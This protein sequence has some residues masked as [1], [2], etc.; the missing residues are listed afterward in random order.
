MTTAVTPEVLTDPELHAHGDPHEVWRWMRRHAPVHRHPATALPAFWSMTRYDDVRAVYRDPE[1]FSSRHGV[2]LRPVDRGVD[3]GG[4]LTLALSDPPRHKQ[5]RAVVADWFST[6]AVRDL[7]ET[8]LQAVRD[9]LD[10]LPA[11]GTCEFAHDVAG[12]LSMY[13][14]GGIIGVPRHDHER[15]FRWTNEAFAAGVSLAAHQ[16]LMRYFID[17]MGRRTAE[18]TDDLVSALLGGTIDGELLTEEEILL[19]CENIIGATEN[20]GLA[21]AGGMLALVQHPDEWRRLA[22]DPEALPG[23]VE[24]ILRWTSSA[25]HSMRT[26]TRDCEVAGQTIAAGDRVVLWVPSA[27][28]DEDVFPEP[29]RFDVGRSP[30]RHLALGSGEHFCLGATLARSQMRLLLKELLE[31]TARIELCG[32]VHRIS[33]IAVSGPESLPLRLVPR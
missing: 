8:T 15:L 23:A 27:N 12:R 9:V 31:R 18:P 22:E 10:R 5:L 6:R 32:P 7:E 26:A 13:L 20:G 14:I 24:E 25:T 21:V 1:T 4:G 3:P 11:D 33:S 30:N 29:Y 17:L 16:D 2:L 19:N 28:R